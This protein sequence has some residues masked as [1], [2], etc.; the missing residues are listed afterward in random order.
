MK[1]V[2]LTLA[3][4]LIALLGYYWVSVRYAPKKE[5]VKVINDKE[6]YFIVPEKMSIQVETEIK[7]MARNER[8]KLVSYR[9]DFNYD[10]GRLKIL[11]IEV[12]KSIFNKKAEVEINEATGKVTVIGENSVKRENLTSG[13]TILAT[14]KIKGLSK[15]ETMVYASRKSETGILDGGKIYEGNFQMPNFKMNFL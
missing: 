8:G 9:A 14:L 13:E 10:P 2:L 15:G 12:N 4:L 7:L 11:D 3:L 6:I 1:Q 5:M